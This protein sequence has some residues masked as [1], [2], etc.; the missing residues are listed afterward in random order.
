MKE[1]EVVDE[2]E[3]EEGIRKFCDT[4][5]KRI[6]DEVKTENTLR[7]ST[8]QR[9]SGAGGAGSIFTQSHSEEGDQVV[10]WTQFNLCDK[11]ANSL[12]G[13]EET[14]KEERKNV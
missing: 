7:R 5:Y 13:R 14:E 12:L 10:Y 11:S 2:N 4:T 8:S 6:Q 1:K 3:E 9:P